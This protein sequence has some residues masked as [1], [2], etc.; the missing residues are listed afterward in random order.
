MLIAMLNSN[1]I[2]TQANV[3]SV[4][5][6]CYNDTTFNLIPPSNCTCL[7]N[8]CVTANTAC[9]CQQVPIP[10]CSCLYLSATPCNNR[11]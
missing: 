8:N 2:E 11:K 9:P 10:N 6:M 1:I 3:V 5:Q 7:N 4:S